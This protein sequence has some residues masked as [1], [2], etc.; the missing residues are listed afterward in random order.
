[1]FCDAI[2]LL[3]FMIGDCIMY[4]VAFHVYNEV[5]EENKRKTVLAHVFRGS[6]SWRKML[7]S[8]EI[9]WDR[10]ACSQI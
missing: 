5:S 9:S 4:L 3:C 7:G 1:V 2:E 8:A 6:Q 10:A